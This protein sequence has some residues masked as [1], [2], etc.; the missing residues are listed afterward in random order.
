MECY[1]QC[2]VEVTLSLKKWTFKL[3]RFV[4]TEGGFINCFNLLLIFGLIRKLFFFI[5]LIIHDLFSQ[6][7]RL[8]YYTRKIANC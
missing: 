1:V 8:F 4:L 6:D 5:I 3:G 7:A 2:Y